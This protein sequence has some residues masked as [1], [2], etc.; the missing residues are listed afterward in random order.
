MI[1]KKLI[2]NL[3]WRYHEPLAAS[4]LSRENVDI[5]FMVLA[6]SD[7]YEHICDT[8]RSFL[9][10]DKER[11]FKAVS[12]SERDVIKGSYLRTL[13]IYM[14]MI[15]ATEKKMDK[16]AKKRSILNGRYG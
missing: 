16:K 15:K 12:E 9:K 5:F 1:I 13:Y 10:E 6:S 4:D 11:Y 2:D 8:F 14:N 7:E 3:F